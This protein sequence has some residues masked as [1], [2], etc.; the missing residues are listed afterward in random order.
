M[1]SGNN[2]FLKIAPFKNKYQEV[3][4]SF[5][6]KDENG[7]VFIDFP[8]NLSDLGER[9]NEMKKNLSIVMAKAYRN[10]FNDFVKSVKDIID[11]NNINVL[12]SKKGSQISLFDK[13]PRVTLKSDVVSGLFKNEVLV[14]DYRLTKEIVKEIVKDIRDN[15]S[16]KF[17]S[18]S[19]C[20][21]LD[22][23]EKK[24]VI[25]SHES[26]DPIFSKHKN[27]QTLNIISDRNEDDKDKGEEED[28]TSDVYWPNWKKKTG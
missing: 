3:V 8:S 2:Y 22:S 23:S 14:G 5:A 17:S 9:E 12:E 10:T 25:A 11:K 26:L 18:E 19:F 21:E 20:V 27:I 16:L 28:D 24:I 13:K 4:D 6:K 7:Q 15:I 1:S